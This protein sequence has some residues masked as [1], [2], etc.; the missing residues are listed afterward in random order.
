MAHLSNDE[1]LI[2]ILNSGID[3]FKGIVAKWRSKDVNQVTSSER[4][5]AKQ[6]CYGILYGIGPKSLS[7]QLEIT[8]IEAIEFIDSFKD[9]YSGNIQ[10]FNNY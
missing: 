6:I 7:E 9:E 5:Q 8:E 4:Q 1:K 2:N 3:V 10:K